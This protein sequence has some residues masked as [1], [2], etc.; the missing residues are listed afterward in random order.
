MAAMTALVWVMQN[1]GTE[2]VGD[3]TSEISDSAFQLWA[4]FLAALPG[5]PGEFTLQRLAAFSRTV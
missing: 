2:Q 3:A 4:S 1:D 5:H